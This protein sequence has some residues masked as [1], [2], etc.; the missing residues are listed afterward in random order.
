MTVACQAP[1][2]RDSTTGGD[3]MAERNTIDYVLGLTDE[4]ARHALWLDRERREAEAYAA[5]GTT[6]EL[7]TPIT[8]SAQSDRTAHRA[9]NPDAYAKACSRILKSM[10]Q[11]LRRSYERYRWDRDPAKEAD[12][13]YQRTMRDDDQSDEEGDSAA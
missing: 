10:E 1:A 5:L 2:V 8:G 13:R 6:S 12:T 7:D 11:G 9:V 4:L 3:R